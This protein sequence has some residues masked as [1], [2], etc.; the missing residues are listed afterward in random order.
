MKTCNTCGKTKP[1]SEFYK[2]AKMA[3]GYLSQCK[4]CKRAYQRKYRLNNLEKVRAKDRERGSLPHRVAARKEYAERMRLDGA[5][6]SRQAKSKREW[7][8]R[9]P[10]KRA[11]HVAVGNAIRDGVLIKEACE[12]CGCNATDAHHDDYTKPLDVRWLCRT[13]HA[14]HH[15]KLRA[16]NACPDRE[17]F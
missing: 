17:A 12:V 10:H 14:E 11:A 16:A 2:H 15:T 1:F 3:G 6:Q 13:H 9:N 5:H 8:K 7:V 4:E